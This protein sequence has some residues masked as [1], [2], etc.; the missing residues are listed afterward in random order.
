MKNYIK[1][2]F[3]FEAVPSK[4]NRNVCYISRPPLI[5]NLTEIINNNILF[6]YF[7]FFFSNKRFEILVEEISF[8]ENNF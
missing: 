1:Y 8:F 7:M 6:S 3:L 2:D 4:H 5:K